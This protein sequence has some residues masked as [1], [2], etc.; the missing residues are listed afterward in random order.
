MADSKKYNKIKK[1]NKGHGTKVWLSE[2]KC[3][4]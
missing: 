2:D 1:I 4:Y 3:K